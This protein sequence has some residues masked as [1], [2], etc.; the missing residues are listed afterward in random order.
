[1]R[2]LLFAWLPLTVALIGGKAP[3]AT[4]VRASPASDL[5]VTVYRAPE[6]DSNSLDLDEL[7]GFALV[8]ET[9]TVSIPQGESRI[10]FEGVADGIEPQSAIITGLPEGV[11]E[12]NQDAHVLTPATL[13]TATLGRKVWMVR[14]NCKTGERTQVTGTLVSNNDGILFK[15]TEGIE[16]LRCSGLPETFHFD[17]A[18]DAS[19]VPTLS[20]LVRS[21]EPTTVQ[22]KLSYLARGFDWMA[23]YSAMVSPDGKRMDLGAWVTL[24]NSNGISFKDAH[25]QVVAGRLNRTSAEVEPIYEAP[26]IVASCWP[27]GTTSDVSPPREFP[28]ADERPYGLED[29][30][31]TGSR[32]EKDLLMPMAL[33]AAPPPKVLVQEEQL[34]DL[35]LYRVPERTSVTSRQIKQVRLLDRAS[36]PVELIYG[37]DIAP[38]A[39]NETQPL[40]KVL[41]T[42]N[43]EAHHLG[44]P[45]PSGQVSAS[46][47]HDGVPLVVG[48][49]PLRDVAVH[50][51]FEINVG[52][53]PDVEVSSVFERRQVDP[54]HPELPLIPGAVDLRQSDV[55]DVHRLEI[56]NARGNPVSVELR[57]HLPGGTSVVR[58]D[59]VPKPRNGLPTFRLTVPAQGSATIRFMTGRTNFTP[60][61]AHKG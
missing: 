11:L 24:A 19:A 9:H 6:R 57:L 23:T 8:T 43:D 29:V 16:A 44:L 59:H 33:A 37:A 3:A 45:L 4:I 17:A 40:S 13:V 10:R 32:R 47:D 22:V 12:K 31:V 50:E 34:G 2:S 53:A 42:R 51:E 35:K 46:Y 1:V 61:P 54:T 52:E 28:D 20:A 15:S 21:P 14:T 38:D 39:S 7:E 18:T 26:E 48:E 56:T 5:S 30:I 25:T 58:S 49:T 36:I 60:V 55:R 41:R 27:M